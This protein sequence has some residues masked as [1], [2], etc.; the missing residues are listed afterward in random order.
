[1]S[2]LSHPASI[3]WGDELILL[4]NEA[5]SAATGGGYGE[6]GQPQL[7]LLTTDAA[8]AL[9]SSFYGGTPMAVQSR[10]LLRSH[11]KESQDHV[12]LLSPLLEADTWVAKGVMAQLFPAPD[13]PEPDASPGR[14][15][16][17]PASSQELQQQRRPSNM[18][19]KR[20]HEIP[21][22]EHPFFHRFAEML[23]NGLAI[24]N[25]KA[26][27]VF[28]NQTFYEL[29]THR[30]ADRSFTSWPQSI[31]PDDYSR[32]I[33]A[34]HEAFTS[35]Q[36]LRTEFRAYG[37]QSPWRLLL[38]T[39]LGDENLRHVSLRE[40]GGFVCSIVDISSEKSAELT[41]R[42][43]ARE[44]QERK[45][46]QERFIDMI[47]HEI[48]NPLSAVL[49]CAEDI[50]DAVRARQSCDIELS[51]VIEAAETIILCVSHQKN[52]VDD[53][54]SFSK[55]DASM[56][57]L[58]PR[59]IQP[60][61]QLGNIL[62]MFQ[63]E[64]RKQDVQFE[65]GVDASYLACSVDWVVADHVRIGQ[66]LI[67]LVSNA[68]KFTAK[69]DGEKKVTV[70]M[71]ASTERPKSYPSDVVFFDPED[72]EYRMDATVTSEWGNGE[73]LYITVA[74]EDT[75]IGISDEG[76]KRL[77]ERFR[78]ATP[79]TEEIYGGSGLGLNISRK[80][81]HLHGG[82]I[83]VS[84]R[85]GQG[86]TFAFFFK[87]RRSG[88]PTERLSRA[89]AEG[90][91]DD[92]KRKLHALGNETDD[93]MD[94]DGLNALRRACSE[95]LDVRRSR[96]SSIVQFEQ[97]AAVSPPRV[98]DAEKEHSGA[99]DKRPSLSRDYLSS[100]SIL[101]SS[102]LSK[103]PDS[104]HEER[105]DSAIPE[106]PPASGTQKRDTSWRAHVL[107][108]EDNVI[109]QRIL[110]RKLESKGFNITTVNNGREAVLA[111]QQAASSS[112]SPSSMFDCILMDQEMPVMDGN[113]ATKAIRKLEA[114]GAIKHIPILG[115]TANV[116]GAQREEMMLA[117]MDDVIHKPYR[118]ED[119]VDR[120]NHL[121]GAE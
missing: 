84:S 50:I 2:T 108:V 96:E 64:L 80:L 59:S 32:V 56:L 98:E 9:R 103:T 36:R 92:M 67:N 10:D 28:V 55:L 45:E 30:G 94:V 99:N 47:S 38:L 19:S 51:D 70:S 13:S 23:P 58:S 93:Y 105:K 52:I 106:A 66:V 61:R 14:P 41:Q 4:H 68:I 26:E 12:V 42:K 39:P 60:K 31:H 116:R 71:G 54:L 77:F 95:P 69:K 33:G 22:D 8:R 34:Y 6:Q 17:L 24:L 102:D 15:H 7:E 78:Q 113:A 44:A 121:V 81:C 79:K 46:Q 11:G 83:G 97:G 63:P 89:D 29:T 1:L 114:Q 49:H 110:Y 91:A 43:A 73:A 48:R 25:H 27:A 117:G 74:V 18:T 85:E 62:R 104:T 90:E 88:F 53:V 5:W 20:I 76:Q 120:I 37:Q 72:H 82:E 16:E 115:V 86:S 35:Q 65:Y 107:L 101:S 87:V 75:G 111:A 112:A 40:Y 3:F 57:S 100:E 109:N 119:I 21:L 118:I